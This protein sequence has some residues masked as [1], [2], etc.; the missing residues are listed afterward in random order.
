MA[1]YRLLSTEQMSSISRAWL[2]EQRPILEGIPQTQGILSNIE[3]AHKGLAI[4]VGG[5]PSKSQQVRELHRRITT[6]DNRHDNLLRLGYSQ[7]TV[8]AAYAAANDNSDEEADWFDFRKTLY[9]N[10]L[11]GSMLSYDEQEGAAVLLE[12]RLDSAMV[13]KLANVVIHLGGKPETLLSLVQ[14]QINLAKEIAVLAR[15]KGK[16]EDTEDNSPTAGDLRRARNSWIEASHV[17]ESALRLA[18]KSQ[19]T[20]QEKAD[21]LVKRLHEEEREA[22]KQYAALKKKEQDE[23]AAKQASASAEPTKEES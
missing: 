10:G 23:E 6:K 20:T 15:M 3:A 19:A 7:C 4:V 1:S 2:V 9:P 13:A 12:K 22:V 21:E 14:E 5:P 17:L 18:V 8:L 16:L 11:R